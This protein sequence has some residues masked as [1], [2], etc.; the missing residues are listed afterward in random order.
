MSRSEELD[1]F[2]SK[3]KGYIDCVSNTPHATEEVK[4]TGEQK[5][6]MREAAKELLS[7]FFRLHQTQDQRS[8]AEEKVVRAGTGVNHNNS[9]MICGSSDSNKTHHNGCKRS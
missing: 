8:F 9:I 2:A 3:L 5:E 7:V 4:A 1:E 6:S